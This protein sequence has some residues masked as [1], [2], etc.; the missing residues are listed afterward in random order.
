M[1]ESFGGRDNYMRPLGSVSTGWD[2]EGLLGIPQ[3][4]DEELQAAGLGR[5]GFHELVPRA[6]AHLELRHLLLQVKD[7]LLYPGVIGLIVVEFF[8]LS[9]SK[10][11][12]RVTGAS[13]RSTTHPHPTS[14]P[15][16]KQEKSSFPPCSF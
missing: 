13:S 9:G 12:V 7:E 16:R 15:L 6:P 5:G 11:I 1:V 4:C 14:T 3:E 8:L 10:V 2:L